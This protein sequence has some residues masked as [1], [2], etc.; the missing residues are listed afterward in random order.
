MILNHI[1]LI[2]SV[3]AGN[4]Q[5]GWPNIYKNGTQLLGAHHIGRASLFLN[6]IIESLRQFVILL[7]PNIP[8]KGSKVLPLVHLLTFELSQGQ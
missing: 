8:T 4:D 7:Q 5:S 2:T 6:T 1:Y 3:H